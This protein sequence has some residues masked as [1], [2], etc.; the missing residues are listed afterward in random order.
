MTS[1]FL[2]L[3]GAS[4]AAACL[5]W[6]CAHHTARTSPREL[7]S[8]IEIGMPRSQVDLLLGAPSFP[9]RSPDQE[10]WYLLPPRIELHESPFAPGTIGIR[11][12]ENGRVA[13]KRLNPQFRR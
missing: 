10:V 1:R 3:I 8:K 9:G 2:N 12:T 7:F 5:A 4:F 6:G 11:F 13:S